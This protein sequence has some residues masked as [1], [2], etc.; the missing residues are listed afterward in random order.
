MKKAMLDQTGSVLVDSF[1]SDSGGVPAHW[2]QI[3]DPHGSVVEK[4]HDV[5]ITDTTG[6]HV[7]IAS[8]TTF[9]P[10]GVVTTIE[11]LINGINAD[12]NAIFGLIGLDGQGNVKGELGA[13]IDASGNV[14]VVVQTEAN[15]VPLPS[16]GSYRGG[17]IALT[18]VIKPDRVR[19]TAQGYDSGDKP[20][21]QL[22]N[23]SLS[24]AF[25]NV[26]IPVLVGA[27]QPKQK[28][29]QAR[30]GSVSVSTQ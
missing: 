7:G 27:S 26:A 12:G 24:A 4:L 17:K 19:V 25:G 14:F 13:G 11:V 21:S 10:E 8:N 9:D 2:S 6:N 29:G 5:T 16:F 18:L 20:F 1:D 28:G 3:L 30:F 15:P 22:G 23:F